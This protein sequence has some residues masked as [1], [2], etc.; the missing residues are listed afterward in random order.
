MTTVTTTATATAASPLDAWQ[1]TG[2]SPTRTD[3]PREAEAR[4]RVYRLVGVI[5]EMF[6]AHPTWNNAQI[7]ET[8]GRTK[9]AVK[10]ARETRGGGQGTE[11]RQRTLDPNRHADPKP[12]VW[13]NGR[14][15]RTAVKDAATTVWAVRPVGP[16]DAQM[17]AKN[18]QRVAHNANATDYKNTRR[19]PPH[20][21]PAP[22][23]APVPT[24]HPAP[25]VYCIRFHDRE[26]LAALIAQYR[27]AVQAVS[28]Q[29]ARLWVD[30][31]EHTLAIHL[32]AGT[33][34]RTVADLGDETRWTWTAPNLP[35][36]FWDAHGPRCYRYPTNRPYP[37]KSE[38]TGEP[39]DADEDEEVEVEVER[40]ETYADVR[41]KNYRYGKGR[42]LTSRQPGTHRVVAPK[43]D[44]GDVDEYARLAAKGAWPVTARVIAGERVLVPVDPVLEK[45]HDI[46]TREG[47]MA[48]LAGDVSR[49][50]AA[51]A[52]GDGW[53]GDGDEGV[54]IADRFHER[55]LADAL[56]DGD[57]GWTW[58]APTDPSE[59]WDEALDRRM[60]KQLAIASVLKRPTRERHRGLDRWLDAFSCRPSDDP[61]F[62]SLL[63]EWVRDRD[64]NYIRHCLTKTANLHRRGRKPWKGPVAA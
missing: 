25:T 29:S 51:D 28:D 38:E 47:K 58:T 18:R 61:G 10:A 15:R 41:R 39:E 49:E 42:E 40:E 35:G 54:P 45:V 6:D 43:K 36:W 30:E 44:G 53:Q 60:T 3:D 14:F 48:W 55:P 33:D 31:T 21:Y 32:P 63:C 34:L 1:T 11:V 19:H 9:E 27:P 7:A 22:K 16:D 64:R 8:L 50:V 57:H 56:E 2:T 52:N 37:A 26:H 59:A 46:N 23:P 5:D 62:A 24:E 4:E 20:P 17:A 12:L 13:D